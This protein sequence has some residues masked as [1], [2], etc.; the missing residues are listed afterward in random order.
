MERWLAS[1]RLYTARFAVKTLMTEFLDGDFDPADPARLA[2]IRTNEYYLQMAVAWYFAT[3]L[4]KRYET[5][6][7]WF[8]PGRLDPTVRKMAVRKARDSF[9]VTP[10]QKEELRRLFGENETGG[11]GLTCVSLASGEEIPLPERTVLCLG[12]FDGVHLGH[13]ALIRAAKELR[14]RDCPGAA[15]GVF[16]FRELSTDLLSKDPPAHLTTPEERAGQFAA[17]GAEIVLYANFEAL[18]GLSPETFVQTVLQ[19]DC[20]CVAAVCGF[21]YRFGKNAAGTAE[22]LR[23]AF[24]GRV[25]VCEAVPFGGAPVSSTRIRAALREGR[26]EEAAQMLGRPYSVCAEVRH[27]KALGRKLGFPTVNQNFPPQAV[28][29]AFGVYATDCEADGKVWRGVTN[30]GVH[31]TVDDP[32]APANCETYLVG[33]HGDLYGKKVR[34]SFLSFLRPERTFPSVEALREQIAR[35][36]EQATKIKNT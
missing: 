34:V 35:D 10:E 15:C 21:N 33:Y 17:A 1:P 24:G 36:A 11:L 29:P 12:N 19:K 28:I 5:I 18:R 7:P 16:C 6:L 14:D 25:E 3:A 2:A 20:R 8:R 26:A 30:V 4:A 22:T 9:R 23:S 27:G 31:P 32:G 13:R